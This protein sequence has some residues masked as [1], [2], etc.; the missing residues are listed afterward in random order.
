MSKTIAVT[1]AT[2]FAG[3]HAVGELLKRG[4]RVSALV[5][6]PARAGLPP[7]VGMV[8]GHLED[9][10]ALATLVRGADAVV[11][12]AG[13]IAAVH[14]EDYF[15]YNTGPTRALAETAA[16]AGVKRFVFASS[17]AAREPELSSYGASKLAAEQALRQFDGRLSTIMLRAPAIHGPGDRATLPLIKQ[18]TKRIAMIPGSR[19][20]RFSLIHVK[21]FARVISDA[22]DSQKTGIVELSDGTPGGYCW[23]D[24]M[25][26]AIDAEGR[27]IQVIFLPKPLVAGVALVAGAMARLTGEPGMINSGKVRELYHGDWVARGP[28]LALDDPIVFARGF[29]E[30]LSWYRKAGWLPPRREADR[31]NAKSHPEA[32]Q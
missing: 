2:G 11:H 25:R 9:A 1:G 5:R 28:G 7:G 32:G 19:E 4:H 16:Q 29:P 27:S 12:L 20:Q 6:D 24:L 22:V 23:D 31:S 14:P 10:A 21:D 18:L 15:R 30:T 26:A 17:L 3:R 8:A 13:V